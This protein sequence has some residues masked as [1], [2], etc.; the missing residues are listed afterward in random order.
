MSMECTEVSEAPDTTCSAAD[1]A[2]HTMHTMLTLGTK[3][4]FDM[5]GI[6]GEAKGVFFCD[7]DN[8]NTIEKC[9]AAANDNDDGTSAGGR[10]TPTMAGALAAM[11][12]AAIATAM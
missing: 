11:M 1:V 10:L 9:L 6:S 5:M 2:A 3:S 12:I 4:T 7:T 8:C